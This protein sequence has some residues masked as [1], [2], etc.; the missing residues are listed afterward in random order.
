[1]LTMDIDTEVDYNRIRIMKGFEVNEYAMNKEEFL[2]EVNNNI[3]NL[4]LVETKNIIEEI[5]KDMSEGYYY[6]TLCKIKNI[7]NNLNMSFEKAK[8]DIDEIYNDFKNIQSGE[9]VFRCYAVQTGNYS[10]FGEEFDYYFYPTNE[11]DE[12]LDRT[13]NTS[14]KLIFLKNYE[15]ALKMIDLILYSNYI[16][17]EISDPEYSEDDEVIDT[18]DT[19]IFSVKNNLTFDLDNII[20]YAIYAI[21]MSNVKDKFKIMDKYLNNT[22]I[23]I[24]KCQNLGIEEIPKLDELYND[25]LKYKN[26]N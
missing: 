3:K 15:V 6:K 4:S 5:C 19:D 24:R 13:Y 16:C 12:L 21:I 8:I 18:F 2:R 14:V 17:E 23:D 25:W 20:L 7:E 1:M 10:A 22:N 9:I 26:S 11:M